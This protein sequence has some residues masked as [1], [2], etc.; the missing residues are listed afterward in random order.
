MESLQIQL[1]SICKQ[2]P[3]SYCAAGIHEGC[4]QLTFRLDSSTTLSCSFGRFAGSARSP[5]ILC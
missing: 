1:L 2:G 3:A 4:K 5:K